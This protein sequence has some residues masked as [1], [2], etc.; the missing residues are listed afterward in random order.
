MFKPSE[1]MTATEAEVKQKGD[2][3]NLD[4]TAMPVTLVDSSR[5]YFVEGKVPEGVAVGQRAHYF[6]AEAG[7]KM[8]V[9]SWTGEE[10]EFYSGRTISVAEVSRGFNLSRLAAVVFALT[11]GRSLATT[12]VLPFFFILALV[13]VVGL[14]VFAGVRTGKRPPAVVVL[15]TARSVL[16]VGQAGELEGRRYRITGDNLVTVAETGLRHARHEYELTDDGDGH[17]AL[18]IAP[19]GTNTGNWT[20]CTLLEPPPPLEPWQAAAVKVGQTVLPD[21][22]P[23]RVSKLFLSTI[24]EA[25]G[26]PPLTYRRGEVLYGFSGA[27]QSNIFIV[28]WNAANIT[29]LKGRVVADGGVR[30]AFPERLEK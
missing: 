13:G 2:R 29:W 18:L 6:N 3:V 10:V 15:P 12:Q 17:A 7:E 11:S 1:A 14:C 28:R 8:M 19:A 21:Q 27:A 4:G 23:V 9:V 5:V 16:K 25:T 24:T 20:F 22:Q 26:I 30:M